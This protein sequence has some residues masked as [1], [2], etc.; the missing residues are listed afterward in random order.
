[1]IRQLLPET[2][3]YLEQTN[4]KH[5]GAEYRAWSRSQVYGMVETQ[6]LL[7][8]LSAVLERNSPKRDTESSYT[9]M[10]SRYSGSR[11]SS[12]M[13]ESR[14]TSAMTSYRCLAFIVEMLIFTDL[15]F[16]DSTTSV[17]TENS[18][19]PSDHMSSTSKQNVPATLEDDNASEMSNLEAEMALSLQVQMAAM[20]AFAYIWSLGAFVPFR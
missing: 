8:L 17:L 14:A 9:G 20:L 12:S 7:N 13:T 3:E 1:M 5:Y 6:T 16:Y 11:A 15:N 2:L 18:S 19:D 10:S 4:L